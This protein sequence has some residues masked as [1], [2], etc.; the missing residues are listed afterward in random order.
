MKKSI[1]LASASPRRRELLSQLQ[2]PFEL[3]KIDVDEQMS[4]DESALDYVR[5][6]AV[7]KARAGAEQ[8]LARLPVLGA[9]TIVVIDGQVLGKPHDK[10]H[11]MQ[12]MQWLS[13]RQHQV[14][15]AVA[16]I[17]GDQ[18]LDVVVST[19]VHFCV[20]TSAMMEAYWQTGEPVDK[21]GGYGIQGI[22]GKFVTR[23]EGSYSAVVGLPLYETEQLLL[24]ME[25][26]A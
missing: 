14:H 13:G 18:Q 17:C 3:I 25:G 10:A 7:S 16:I 8:V 11:F 26:I 5:R 6:L 9:D 22:G 21:A 19:Q 1:G 12:M 15:T 4:E 2:Q 20:L 24:Q 23:I